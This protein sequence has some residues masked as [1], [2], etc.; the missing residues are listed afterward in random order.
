LFFYKV[1]C[2]TCQMAGPPMGSFARAHPGRVVGIG[3]DPPERLEEFS[4]R[5]GVSFPSV[6]DLP[7]YE[8]SAAFGVRTVPT[9]FLVGEDGVVLDVVEA[10]DRDGLNRLARRLSELTG[11]DYRPVSDHSDGLPAY[12]PG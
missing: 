3:Q 9:T 10:W 12:R 2:P 1:T 8:L 5:Y 6:P 11:S 7:P 4:A